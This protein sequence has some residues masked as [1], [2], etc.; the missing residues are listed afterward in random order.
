MGDVKPTTLPTPPFREPIERLAVS[1]SEAAQA[2]GISRAKLY[3]LLAD[4][5]IPSAR[6]GSR[7]LIRCSALASVLEKLEA[8]G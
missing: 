5:T 8:A 4:G 6:L 3:Q 1:P 7:R 2:L